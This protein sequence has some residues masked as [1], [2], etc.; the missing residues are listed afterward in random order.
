EAGPTPDPAPTAAAWQAQPAIGAGTGAAIGQL[1]YPNAPALSPDGLI[2]YVTDTNN[3][4][5]AVW[6]RSAVGA[7]WAPDAPIGSGPG[8]A[9]DQFD[10]PYG[11]ALSADGRELFVSDRDDC[12]VVVWRKG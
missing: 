3:N 11:L 4:R 10:A 9:I 12:R 1:N 6:K 8:A 7:P 2:L 5:I